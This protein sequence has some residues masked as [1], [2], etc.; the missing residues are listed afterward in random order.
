MAAQRRKLTVVDRTTIDLRLRDGWGIR[1]SALAVGRS[2]GMVADEVNRTGGPAAYD[3]GA[4][5][6]QAAAKRDL[7]GRRPRMARDGPLFTEAAR[8]P[9]RGWG[10]QRGS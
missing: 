4:A 9:G 6:G 10:A 3:A 8:R 2:A 5:E 1:Q 7:T